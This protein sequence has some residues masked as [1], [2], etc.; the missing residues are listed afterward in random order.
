MPDIQLNIRD[1]PIEPVTNNELCE[2]F[3]EIGAKPIENTNIE[4]ENG[5]LEETQL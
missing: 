5:I 3:N 4:F 1:L 2:S